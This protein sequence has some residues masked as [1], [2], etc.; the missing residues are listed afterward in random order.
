MTQ[1]DHSLECGFSGSTLMGSEDEKDPMTRS[2]EGK[3]NKS[4]N[5]VTN[6]MISRSLWK[7]N[8]WR[9]REIKFRN[10][11]VLYLLLLDADGSIENA[12]RIVE[13]FKKYEDPR[14]PCP[15][16]KV[17]ISQA[18]KKIFPSYLKISLKD[19]LQCLQFCENNF[20]AKSDVFCDEDYA[21]KIVQ[22]FTKSKLEVAKSV[23]NLLATLKILRET[24]KNIDKLDTNGEYVIPD[25]ENAFESFSRSMESLKTEEE[26]LKNFQLCSTWILKEVKFVFNLIDEM[27]EI[28]S[29]E[30]LSLS[31]SK[32]HP[33]AIDKAREESLGIARTNGDVNPEKIL[34]NNE[35]EKDSDIVVKSRG[36]KGFTDDDVSKLLVTA[37]PNVSPPVATSTPRNS[38]SGSGSSITS[39][40]DDNRYPISSLCDI[41]ASGDDGL[42]ITSK[43]RK[44]LEL[45]DD[46]SGT[47]NSSVLDQIMTS[48]PH[49]F[50]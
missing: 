39:K 42:K 3:V 5:V 22:E 21:R 25:I 40:L 47:V 2:S 6:T 9:R 46:G 10:I 37:D 16:S 14:S 8:C 34:N 35:V 7:L 13:E 33:Q 1:D 17:R 24:L 30:N 12:R 27:L 48:C 11:E 18:L 44:L 23:N 32:E 19:V 36:D 26:D 38:F 49:L 31:K 28:K 45:L 43:F 50:Q 15:V 20:R 29:S 41:I 4:V